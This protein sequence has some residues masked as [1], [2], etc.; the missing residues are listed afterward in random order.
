[1]VSG[2]HLSGAVLDHLA[3][4]IKGHGICGAQINS[5]M[6]ERKFD[7][8]PE[9]DALPDFLH[10]EEIVQ[11]TGQSRLPELVRSLLAKISHFVWKGTVL[12]DSWK[13]HFQSLVQRV[14]L[15][16]SPRDQLR[17]PCLLNQEFVADVLFFF[18]FILHLL[19]PFRGGFH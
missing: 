13:P 6:L 16:E 17:P 15:T 9:K 5:S 3:D 18:L 12:V 11:I 10:L 4:R 7:E 2:R 14:E 19:E 1:M 8:L